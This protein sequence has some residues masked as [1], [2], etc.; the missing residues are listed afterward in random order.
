MVA[1]ILLFV[2]GIYNSGG[3]HM[4]LDAYTD[5]TL[6]CYYPATWPLIAGGVLSL[7]ATGTA[8]CFYVVAISDNSSSSDDVADVQIPTANYKP[9][10]VPAAAAAAIGIPPGAYQAGVPTPGYY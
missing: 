1:S 2:G 4:K 8:I 10:A 9:S 5:G 3:V 6:L 7:F